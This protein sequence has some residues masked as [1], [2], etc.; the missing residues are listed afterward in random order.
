M[1]S[2]Y[3]AIAA[4]PGAPSFL[5]RSVPTLANRLLYLDAI[6]YK[7]GSVKYDGSLGS[8]AP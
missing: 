5:I 2:H 3:D 4:L 6:L 8:R 1:T 7:Y